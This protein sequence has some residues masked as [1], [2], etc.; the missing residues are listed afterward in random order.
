M[1]DTAAVAAGPDDDLSAQ[2][3]DVLRRRVG[4]PDM[5]YAVPPLPVTGGFW[6]DIVA[7]RLEGAPPELQ[8]DLVVRIMPDVG[9]AEK[10]TVVQTEVVAQGFPAPRV[11]LTGEANDG[12]GRPFM[13]MDHVKGR[14]P[15]P[16]VSGGPAAMA[17]VGRAALRL[18]DLL[19]GTAARLH[20]LDP[21]PLRRR[22]EDVE[23]LFVDVA[24]LLAL[25]EE[26]AAD[27]N[28]PDLVDAILAMPGKQRRSGREV[29]CHGDLHPFNLLVDDAGQVTVIDWSVALVADP[30][31]DLAFTALTMAMAPIDV[32]RGL[33]RVVRA[34]ARTAS[35]S[36]LRRYRAHA[37]GAAASLADDVLEWYTAV[38]CLRALVEVAQWVD[39][40]VADEKAGHPWLLMGPQMAAHVGSLVGHDV[41][42]I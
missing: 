41:R 40:G 6:A 30:A 38:H 4:A 31:F 19:A 17:A 25:L 15:M 39:T 11:R 42:P 36:F 29:I 14:T 2:L 13:V 24:G 26:R 9:I 37:P 5:S 1:D 20:A 7:I 21:A 16:E 8:G 18:P 23:A 22:L 33:R 32:P 3:L 34:G 28:R 35:R 12:L 27:V 10:E